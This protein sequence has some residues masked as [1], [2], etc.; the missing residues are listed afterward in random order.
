M[1]Y[2]YILDPKTR[3]AQ[4]LELQNNILLLDEAHNVEKTCE[5]SA[6]LQV[7]YWST[8]CSSAKSLFKFPTVSILIYERFFYLDKQHG[9]SH[10]YR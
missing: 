10:L 8:C 9:Y 3:K 5:E 7:K 2:N 1:P 6:S 4:G